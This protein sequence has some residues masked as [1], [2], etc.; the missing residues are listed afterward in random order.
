MS[1]GCM[2]RG[3][4]WRSAAALKVRATVSRR[5]TIQCNVKLFV[6]SNGRS[7]FPRNTNWI[8][9]TCKMDQDAFKSPYINLPPET[10]LEESGTA[11]TSHH[12]SKR[13]SLDSIE[14]QASSGYM[15]AKWAS[16]AEEGQA[17]ASHKKRKIKAISDF[18]W[19]ES[20][21][22]EQQDDPSSQAREARS[23]SVTSIVKD[24][25]S[26]SSDQIKIDCVEIDL[27]REASSRPPLSAKMST[28]S[29]RVAP[30]PEG[31]FDYMDYI[32]RNIASL[33]HLQRTTAR[34]MEALY[35]AR[36]TVENFTLD[37]FLR[38]QGYPDE[39]GKAF[40]G[41]IAIVGE[42]NDAE[43]T[44]FE[45]YLCRTWPMTGHK[46]CMVFSSIDWVAYEKQGFAVVKG[47]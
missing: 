42:P 37:T 30:S 20:L 14:E 25:G 40:R 26:S 39:R 11:L 10:S 1:I 36:Y 12:K 16:D 29:F 6:R 3:P 47:E 2:R 31:A 33:M 44:T 15:L 34:S 17:L 7:V 27:S 9:P 46:I 19:Y 23:K 43:A 35:T 18:P 41:A 28:Q 8:Q 38:E 22:V 32:K 24:Q 4:E 45:E 5:L 13:S 21:P